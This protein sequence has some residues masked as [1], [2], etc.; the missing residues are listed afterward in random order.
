M[1]KGHLFAEVTYTVVRGVGNPESGFVAG[2]PTLREVGIFHAVLG[3]GLSPEVL[4]REDG[5]SSL[6]IGAD[7][8]NSV[9][10]VWR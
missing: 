5:G 10:Q 2:F 9:A 1:G 4:C 7:Q 8:A 3:E 6:G